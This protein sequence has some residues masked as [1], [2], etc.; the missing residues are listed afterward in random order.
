MDP[1][2]WTVVFVALMMPTVQRKIIECSILNDAIVDK[3]TIYI[4]HMKEQPFIMQNK[5]VTKL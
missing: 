2:D 5:P 4:K 1:L 3:L